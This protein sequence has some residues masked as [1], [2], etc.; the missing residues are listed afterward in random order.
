M[1]G[2][3]EVTSETLSGSWKS[4]TVSPDF[5]KGCRSRALNYIVSEDYERKYYF[6]ECS[7]VSFQNDQGKTIW[8]TSGSGEIEIPAGVAVYVKFGQSR[9]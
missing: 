4:L 1:T 9:P 8:T 2:A 7:E 6:H 5:F 3:E